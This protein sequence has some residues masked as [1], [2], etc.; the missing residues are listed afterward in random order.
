MVSRLTSSYIVEARKLLTSTKYILRILKRDQK[1]VN[2]V[3]MGTKLDQEEERFDL[4]NIV[5]VEVGLGDRE[6]FTLVRRDGNRMTL[7]TQERNRLITEI[8]IEREN[9]SYK[10]WQSI[11]GDARGE[12]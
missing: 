2:I 6:Q 11:S 12:I 5:G 1:E 3:L 9:L 4:R 7:Y 8:A 10:I